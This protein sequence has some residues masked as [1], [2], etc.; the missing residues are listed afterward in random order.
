MAEKEFQF[1]E[2]WQ[3]QFNEALARYREEVAILDSRSRFLA[4]HPL[5][6][7]ASRI[8]ILKQDWLAERM[9]LGQLDANLREFDVKTSRRLAGIKDPAT[10]EE[11][12]ELAELR[13]METRFGNKD[14]SDKEFDDTLGNIQTYATYLRARGSEKLA[15]QILDI[16]KGVPSEN[17]EFAAT[18]SALNDLRERVERE[19]DI[20]ALVNELN[21]AP[22]AF[23]GRYRD[24][25]VVEQ[26]NE[27]AKKLIAMDLVKAYW[28]WLN[29]RNPKFRRN[30]WDGFSKNVENITEEMVSKKVEVKHLGR[31]TK[32]SVEDLYPGLANRIKGKRKELKGWFPGWDKWVKALVDPATIH[33]LERKFTVGIIGFVNTRVTELENIKETTMTRLRKVVGKRIKSIEHERKKYVGEVS[34][35]LKKRISGIKRVRGRLARGVKGRISD[36]ET[37]IGAANAGSLNRH[38]KEEEVRE[39]VLPIAYKIREII[40]MRTEDCHLHLLLV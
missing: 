14:I 15:K 12:E 18:I 26:V 40:N 35:V 8:M 16:R 13:E 5:G 10:K 3:A 33:R 2:K 28:A 25:K 29:K 23:W 36:I 24:R 9:S 21:S 22:K 32:A 38:R 19:R 20:R 34:G 7:K 4:E 6:M 17:A 39:D 31:R 37:D 11:I 27:R 30:E 1:D